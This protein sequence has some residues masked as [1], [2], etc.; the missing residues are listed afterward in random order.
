MQ[1]F[2]RWMF[3]SSRLHHPTTVQ[4]KSWSF[5]SI[6]GVMRQ[7]QYIL[8]LLDFECHWVLWLRTLIQWTTGCRSLGD[9][10][11]VSSSTARIIS[12]WGEGLRIDRGRWLLPSEKCI[13][14]ASSICQRIRSLEKNVARVISNRVTKKSNSRVEGS[15]WWT[16]G[17]NQKLLQH[18][19]ANGIS[20][21]VGNLVK[22]KDIGPIGP[23]L[24]FGSKRNGQE[25]S[26]FRGL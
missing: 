17:L 18:H 19:W 8:K 23:L 4:R 12:Q 3:L 24:R 13:V 11:R 7:S 26:F 25:T 20:F 16:R 5:P 14:W 2:E 15:V 1:Y 9:A 10:E 21:E 6:G 22:V